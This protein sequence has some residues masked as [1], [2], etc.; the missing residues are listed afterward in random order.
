MARDW[1]VQM[2]A[3]KAAWGIPDQVAA[4]FTAIVNDAGAA[5]E[6]S[7]N[8]AARTPVANAQCREAFRRLED[9]ARDIKRR[10]FLR[11]P[12]LESDVISL[13][14]KVKDRHPTKHGAPAAQTT[15]E[16]FLRGRHELGFRIVYIT[17]SPEEAANKGY[18]IWYKVV[19]PGEAPPEGPEELTRSFYTQRKKD[20]IPF[21]YGDSG[22]MVH[23]AVQVEN[24]GLKGPW[25]PM[26]SAL[27]P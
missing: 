6:A 1:V 9:A 21:A 11:P 7:E 12:L 14:L 17:G 10:Y 23:M 13:S 24:G 15:L 25:G 16:T 4:D 8:E 27:I 2:N 3:K 26:V 20:V 18:R 19:P 22:R 5:L